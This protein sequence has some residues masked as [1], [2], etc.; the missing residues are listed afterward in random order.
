MGQIAVESPTLLVRPAPVAHNRKRHEL[1][2]SQPLA[3]H[4]QSQSSAMLSHLALTMISAFLVL[5]GQVFYE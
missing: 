4:H 5:V 2:S 3:R 1:A